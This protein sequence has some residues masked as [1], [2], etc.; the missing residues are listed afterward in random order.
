TILPQ[1]TI[2]DLYQYQ[3]TV[4]WTH[5]RQTWRIG[6]DI[7]R[8]IEIDLVAQNAYGGLIYNSGGGASALDNFLDNYLGSSG[9]ASKTFGPTRVDPHSWRTAAFGQDDVKLTPELTL[10]LGLRY[11]YL[12]NPENSLPYPAVDINNPFQSVTA[13]VPVINDRNN[14]APR[15]GF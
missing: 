13:V 14:F 1:G 10:N 15:F 4:S 3:D 7:G 2:Q 9:T 11:D 5:G 8:D 6:T 12:T